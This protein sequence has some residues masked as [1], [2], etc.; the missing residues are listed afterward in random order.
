MNGFDEVIERIRDVISQE[1]GRGRV[2][3]RDVARALDLTPGNLATLK[4]RDR[5]P[6]ESIAAFCAK[7][8][9]SINWL[10]FDQSAE[11]LVANT[12]KYAYVRYFKDVRVSAGGGAFDAEV[13]A[14]QLPLP[15][16][17][18]EKLGG[19]RELERIEAVN[20]TGDSMEPT[21]KG[22]DILFIHRDRQNF[23][24]GGVFAVA[25]PHGLF[26][27]RL[28]LQVDGALLLIS[29]NADYP[30]QKVT[31]GE[32]EVLGQAVAVFSSEL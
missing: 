12:E 14:E 3:D 10:L 1:I 5:L 31:S 8:R 30:P 19:E 32:V 29:D 9:I 16:V 7:R 17:W 21:L 22:G 15:P 6:M 11:S 18:V 23:R 28:E 26:V 4:S 2:M 24:R 27:K 20:V 25:T 13:E